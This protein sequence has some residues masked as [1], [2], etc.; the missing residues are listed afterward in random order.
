MCGSTMMMICDRGGMVFSYGG[1]RRRGYYDRDTTAVG[2]EE[3]RR[4][5]MH[6]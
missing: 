6:R 3:N 2:E 1:V 4:R 5:E